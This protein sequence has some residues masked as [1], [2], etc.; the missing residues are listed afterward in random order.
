MNRSDPATRR[1]LQ[2]L[3]RLP[4]PLWETVDAAAAACGELPYRYV[5]GFYRRLFDRVP[6]RPHE[7]KD[8]YLAEQITIRALKDRARH[9]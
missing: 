3:S 4:R 6:V 8:A 2:T 5:E 9:Q 7:I 1:A